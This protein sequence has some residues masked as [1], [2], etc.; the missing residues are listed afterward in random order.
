MLEVKG[1]A[2]VFWYWAGVGVVIALTGLG[3]WDWLWEG[4]VLLRTI[5]LSLVVSGVIFVVIGIWKVLD[6]RPVIV[7]DDKGM[8]DR[9]SLPSRMLS[10]AEVRDFRLI[11]DRG[12]QLCWLAIDLVDPAQFIDKALLGSGALLEELEKK[13]GTPCVI[14]L[15]TLKI[16]PHRLLECLKSDLRHQQR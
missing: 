6:K 8:L 1:R 10:W 15:K 14:A 7:V 2:I 13:Y 3:C 5:P 16:E 9:T 12:G 11:S 4:G